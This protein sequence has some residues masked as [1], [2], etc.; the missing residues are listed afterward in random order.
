[1]GLSSA[2]VMASGAELL[3]QSVAVGVVDVDDRPLRV[4]F[5]EQLALGVEVV[6]HRRMEVEMVLRQVREDRGGEMDRVG[7]VELK[8]VA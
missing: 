7:A 4:E 6:L 5:H 2:N 3:R 1:M 8:G